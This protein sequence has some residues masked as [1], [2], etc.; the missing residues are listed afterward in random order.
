MCKYI[1]TKKELPYSRT[2]YKSKC[3]FQ[4]MLVTGYNMDYKSND[5]GKIIHPS[6]KCMLCKD[7]IE[8]VASF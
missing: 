3:G 7:E 4:L 5:Y 6:G 8:I 1:K 2:Y